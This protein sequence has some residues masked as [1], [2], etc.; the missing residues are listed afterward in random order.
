MLPF[1]RLSQQSPNLRVDEPDADRQLPPLA[2]PFQPAG[3]EDLHLMAVVLLEPPDTVVEYPSR[4]HERLAYQRREAVDQHSRHEGREDEDGV[5]LKG[6]D[7]RLKGIVIQPV[8]IGRGR[9]EKEIAQRL[10]RVPETTAILLHPRVNELVD[11]ALR[12]R[13]QVLHDRVH[14]R[15]ADMGVRDV[16]VRGLPVERTRPGVA[17]VI[18]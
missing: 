16:V 4:L 6:P 5:S 17:D 9:V 2:E 11:P 14:D 3:Q 12:Q 13:R 18:G 10:R 15:I 8:R 7:A 1:F